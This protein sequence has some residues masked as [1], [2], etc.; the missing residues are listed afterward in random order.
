M[1]YCP[2]SCPLLKLLARA[3]S[4]KQQSS[5]DLLKSR[6]FW[7][8]SV[9]KSSAHAARCTRILPW[10][11]RAG[12]DSS[13]NREMNPNFHRYKFHSA[14]KLP[15]LNTSFVQVKVKFIQ[16]DSQAQALK[17]CLQQQIWTKIL[18]NWLRTVW[19]I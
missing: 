11:D 9:K 14:V 1:C 18:G 3:T 4:Q 17:V 15:F 16:W 13:E 5:W 7:G 19:L 12:C 6:V 10:N 8:H 2:S